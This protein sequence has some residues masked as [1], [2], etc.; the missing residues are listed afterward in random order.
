VLDPEGSL[1]SMSWSTR[2][3][4]GMRKRGYAVVYADGEASLSPP[5]GCYLD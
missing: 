2:I 4:D 1:A 3:L 5:R